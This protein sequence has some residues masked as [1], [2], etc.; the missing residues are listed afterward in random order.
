MAMTHGL[1]GWCTD[2]LETH[3]ERWL[4]WGKPTQ[5]VRDQGVESMDQPAGPTKVEAVAVSWGAPDSL[6]QD[7]LRIDRPIVDRSR[8]SQRISVAVLTGMS[9]R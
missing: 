2:P 3:E 4:S 6:G 8:Q 1:E 9:L 7:L 5:L